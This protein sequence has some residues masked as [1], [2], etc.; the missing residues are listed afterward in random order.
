MNS[1][2]EETELDGSWWQALDSRS[3]WQWSLSSGDILLHHTIQYTSIKNNPGKTVESSLKWFTKI[4]VLFIFKPLQALYIYIY[5]IYY[6]THVM[7]LWVFTV[8]V[9]LKLGQLVQVPF[10]LPQP[11]SWIP[12]LFGWRWGNSTGSKARPVKDS[13]PYFGSCQW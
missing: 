12:K 1:T 4:T 2:Y 3:L 5:A 13:C 9:L 6:L 11:I 10:L 8:E 7:N